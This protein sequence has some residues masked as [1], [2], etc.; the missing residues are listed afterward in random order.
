[1]AEVDLFDKYCSKCKY[2]S[3]S[4]TEIPCDKCIDDF[5]KDWR[6]PNRRLMGF[7]KENNNNV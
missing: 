7:E 3:V 6:N 4:E 2:T 1:M 5:V